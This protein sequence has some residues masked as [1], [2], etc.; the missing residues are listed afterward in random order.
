MSELFSI[1]VELHEFVD[2]GATMVMV[3]DKKGKQA[4]DKH[5]M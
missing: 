1:Q 3:G 2:F 4:V 5:A